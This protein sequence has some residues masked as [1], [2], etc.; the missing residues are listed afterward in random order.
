MVQSGTFEVLHN[1][2]VTGHYSIGNRNA[3][4]FPQIHYKPNILRIGGKANQSNPS[5]RGRPATY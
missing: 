5:L 4:G 1:Y 3:G 2:N